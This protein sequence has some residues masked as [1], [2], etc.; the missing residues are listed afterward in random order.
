LN[1]NRRLLKFIKKARGPNFKRFKLMKN[2]VNVN[3][4][5]LLCE[6]ANIKCHESNGTLDIFKD[7]LII[8]KNSI[9]SS[10]SSINYSFHMIA[11]FTVYLI[12]IF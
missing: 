4:Y 3:V 8:E 9:D 2:F 7:Y 1:F 12:Q 10:S 6:L 5:P 11:V